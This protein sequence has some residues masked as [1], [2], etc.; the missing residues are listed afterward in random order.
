MGSDACMLYTLRS[1]MLHSYVSVYGN[2]FLKEYNSRKSNWNAQYTCTVS[3]T[4]KKYYA[5][6]EEKEPNSTLEKSY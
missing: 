6:E 1:R 5:E 2:I 3:Q 4:Q